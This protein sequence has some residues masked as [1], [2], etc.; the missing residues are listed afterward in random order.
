MNEERRADFIIEPC[1]MRTLLWKPT[2]PFVGMFLGSV[3]V[4]HFREWGLAESLLIGAG[5]MVMGVLRSCF[6]GVVYRGNGFRMNQEFATAFSVWKERVV[7]MREVSGIRFLVPASGPEYRNG[8]F[9]KVELELTTGEKV[10][11]KVALFRKG[12]VR[13]SE[14]LDEVAPLLGF[15]MGERSFKGVG[16]WRK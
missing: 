10:K 7:P 13:K 4:G 2:V 11:H 16:F 8:G 6:W 15:E 9:Q 5:F 1:S 12:C 3:V 14:E